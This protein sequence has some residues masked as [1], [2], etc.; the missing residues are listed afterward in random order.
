MECRFHI[1]KF[2]EKSSLT[3]RGG[4]KE[5]KWTCCAALN[6]DSVGC[7]MG[8]HIEDKT[9]TQLLNRFN[10]LDS[11]SYDVHNDDNNNYDNSYSKTVGIKK[12]NINSNSPN[13]TKTVTKAKIKTE[14]ESDYVKIGSCVYYRHPVALTDT[15]AGIALKYNTNSA[16]IKKN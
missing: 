8:S 4:P 2:K 11:D 15:L 14:V 5:G 12:E 13:T 1:G 7:G 16:T 3:L 9:T 6:P 10:I